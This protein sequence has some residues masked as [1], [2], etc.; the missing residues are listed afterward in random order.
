MYKAKIYRDEGDGGAGAGQGGAAG[1]GQGAGESGAGGGEPA[2]KEMTQA[3]LDALVSGSKKEG[4]EKLARQY[5][6]TTADG[7]ADLKAF[8]AFVTA[9][10]KRVDDDKTAEEK[11]A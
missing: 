2:K 4:A 5:G 1:A 10:K 9:S 7:K 8:E 11:A 6:F 3:E